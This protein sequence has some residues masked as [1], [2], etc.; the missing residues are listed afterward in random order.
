M[1]SDFFNL[2]PVASLTLGTPLHIHASSKICPSFECVVSNCVSAVNKTIDDISFE[3]F[4]LAVGFRELEI[5]SYGN[6]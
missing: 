5:Q 2:K 6:L 3:Q 1:E 4:G